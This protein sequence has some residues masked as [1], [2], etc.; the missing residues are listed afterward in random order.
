MNFEQALSHMKRGGTVKLGKYS[1]KFAR[2]SGDRGPM[3][4]IIESKEG[5]DYDLTLTTITVAP[6]ELLSSDWE[7]V[8]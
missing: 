1:Y 6:K 7:I 5:R 8:D 3:T 2:M 4:L